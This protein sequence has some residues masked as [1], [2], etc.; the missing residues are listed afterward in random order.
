M[1]TLRNISNGFFGM[2]DWEATSKDNK[3]KYVDYATNDRKLIAM[4]ADVQ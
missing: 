1:K 3:L 2:D 4:V